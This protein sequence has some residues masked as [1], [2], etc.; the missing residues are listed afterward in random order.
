VPVVASP[1]PLAVR[2]TA[3]TRVAP[4]R[5][6]LIVGIVPPILGMCGQIMA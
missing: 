4:R 6:V 2:T 3:T 5:R 1:A